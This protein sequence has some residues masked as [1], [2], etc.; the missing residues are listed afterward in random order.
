MNLNPK[1]KTSRF[2]VTS[3]EL[4]G[5]GKQ[6]ASVQVSNPGRCSIY[7]YKKHNSM[8]EIKSFRLEIVEQT[9]ANFVKTTLI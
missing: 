6:Q 3:N 5:N 9:W 4:A 8:Q 2:E 1:E 7:N